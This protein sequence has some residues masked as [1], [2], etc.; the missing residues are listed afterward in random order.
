MVDKFESF[1]EYLLAIRNASQG[2]GTDKRLI[3]NC[4][5]VQPLS[6][7]ELR[8]IKLEVM[9]MMTVK[10]LKEILKDWPDVN[11]MGEPTEIWLET[12]LM[13]SSQASNYSLLGWQNNLLLES[14]AFENHDGE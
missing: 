7:D 10:E 11:E 1:G 4:K 8:G 3:R 13:R 14:N 12:G 2:K 6:E 9:P 5:K